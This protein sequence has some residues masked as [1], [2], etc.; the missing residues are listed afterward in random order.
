MQLT[1]VYNLKQNLEFGTGFLEGFFLDGAWGTVTGL[2]GLAKGGFNIGV[3]YLAYEMA[4]KYD[5]IF[6]TNIAQNTE[7]A[8]H[9]QDGIR[10]ARQFKK[11]V[12]TG[13]PYAKAIYDDLDI[14]M[15]RSNRSFSPK[16]FKVM[17]IT[18]KVMKV[19][20]EEFSQ[21]RFTHRQKGRILGAVSFEVALALATLGAGAAVGGA[22]KAGKLGKLSKVLDSLPLPKGMANRIVEKVKNAIG[23]AIGGPTANPKLYSYSSKGEFV[24]DVF[25]VKHAGRAWATRHAPGPWAFEGGLGNTLKRVLLTGKIKQFKSV[26]EITGPARELFVKV[27]AIGPARGWKRLGGQHFTKSPGNVDLVTGEIL[28]PTVGQWLRFGADAGIYYTVDGAFL[29]A[30]GTAIYVAADQLVGG[31]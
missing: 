31:E 21:I 23:D 4:L 16:T 19:V 12:D 28:K 7:F 3:D 10:L 9:M 6:R 27:R 13:G 2:W 15:G 29:V 5:F 1:T 14:F 11:A 25:K 30:G 20:E 17:Q 8:G 18:G 26:K 24:G 22:A